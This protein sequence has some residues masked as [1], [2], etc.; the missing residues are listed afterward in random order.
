MP[1]IDLGTRDGRREALARMFLIREFENAVK[2]RFADGEIPGFVHLSLGQEGVAVGAAG[3]LER[4]DMITSTH[5]GHGHAL[6][7]GLGPGPLMA[8]IYGKESGYCSG[9]GGSM[10]VAAPALGMLGAQ[11]IVGAGVPVAVGAALTAQ[12]RDED[13]ATVAFLGDGA[14]AAGQVHEGLNLGATWSLPLVFVVEN[15]LYSE[16]MAFDEQH[17]IDE[18]AEAAAAY[19]VPGVVVDG[20][21]VEAV[22]ETVRDARDRAMAG[23]GPTLVEAKTYRYRGHFEGDQEP[24]RESSE[25][26]SWRENR[27][28]IDGFIGRLED[29]GEVD[30]EDVEAIRD[31]ATKRIEEAVEAARSADQP[32]PTAAYEDVFVEPVGEVDRFRAL[33]KPAGGDR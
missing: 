21:D 2:D 28:P 24:Y 7:R 15:N 33:Y 12:V 13:R 29:A 17:N 10:H 11:A 19:G 27:D 8:E 4:E 22:H 16:G 32:P 9:K 1:A 14:V 3:A 5:R 18:V 23:E 6:A 31:Q 20:Q 25:V 30:E 26:E